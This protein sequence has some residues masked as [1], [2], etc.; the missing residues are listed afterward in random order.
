MYISHVFS[1]RMRVC[2]VKTFAEEIVGCL[3][4]CIN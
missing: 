1:Y 3:Y 2:E 4:T